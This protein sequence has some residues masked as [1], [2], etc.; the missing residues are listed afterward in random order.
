MKRITLTLMALLAATSMAA[1]QDPIPPTPPARPA[2]TPAPSRPAR[3][4]P[5]AR[6]IYTPMAPL[7]FIDE[8]HIREMAHEAAR[9]S[10]EH[11]DPTATIHRLENAHRP[12]R[13]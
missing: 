1:A 8:E 4:A 2:P 9:I 12:A 13:D 11:L 10:V 3:P 5:E 6:P 7:P